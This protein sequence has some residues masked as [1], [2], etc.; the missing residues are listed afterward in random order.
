MR[1]FEAKGRDAGKPISIAVANIEQARQ[2]AE[3][4]ASAEALAKRFLP[5]PL[6]IILK[7]RTKLPNE[8]P[9]NFPSELTCGKDSIGVRIVDHPVALELIELVGG[10]I[11]ATSAN[12]SGQSEPRTADDAVRQIGD[13]VDFVLDAGE[14]PIG[15]PSTVV[16]LTGERGKPKI[17]REGAITKGEIEEVL[18]FK[19]E[20]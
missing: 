11:T 14:C 19:V 12:I 4:N 2:V 5:G 3:W 13:K 7:K 20:D 17:I 18:S 15:K 16:D 6:T 10:P 9:A 1:I 8:F